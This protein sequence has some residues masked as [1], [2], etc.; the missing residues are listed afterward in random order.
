MRCFTVD[1]IVTRGINITAGTTAVPK[2][3]IGEPGKGSA[4]PVGAEI[5]KLFG[6]RAIYISRIREL[7]DRAKTPALEA[8]SHAELHNMFTDAARDD[9][10]LATRLRTAKKANKEY[11]ALPLYL[12][13]ARLWAEDCNHHVKLMH[14][15][16]VG[17]GDELQI[18]PGR[19]HGQT[20]LVHVVTMAPLDGELWYESS[21]WAEKVID[22][23]HG[24]EVAKEYKEFPPPG[25]EI[26]SSG[27][28][29]NGEINVLLHM[30]PRSSFRICRSGNFETFGDGPGDP[31]RHP[32]M[33]VSFVRGTLW[34]NPGE[35]VQRIEAA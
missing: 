35:S 15:N 2:L 31:P 4:I 9:K 10:G 8:S 21:S 12:V 25:I 34:V 5:K 28:G 26:L 6:E 17:N 19:A 27:W 30:Q 20:C 32:V 18:V 13:Y 1:E 29:P 24:S 11:Q 3:I 33:S 22:T 14:A 23:K 7:L 16:A